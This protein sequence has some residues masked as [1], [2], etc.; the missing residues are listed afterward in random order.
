[1]FDMMCQSGRVI[2]GDLAFLT[3]MGVLEWLE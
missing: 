3:G 2:R 1:M